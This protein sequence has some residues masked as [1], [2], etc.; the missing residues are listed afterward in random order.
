MTPYTVTANYEHT[1]N[2]SGGST[3]AARVDGRYE[4][5]HLSSNLHVDYLRVNHDQ[6]VHL[7][8]RAIGNVSATWASSDS[9]YVVSAYVRNFT[10]KIYNAYGVNADL[11]RVSV[12][13][14]DPRTYGAQ[15]S[16]RF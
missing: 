7:G 8:A 6:Y 5:A 16:V 3:L 2:M 10:D 11:T 14:S 12:T 15:A 13:Y 1:F 4:A 9:R